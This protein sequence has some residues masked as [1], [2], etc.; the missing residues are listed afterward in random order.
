MAG[1]RRPYL[2]PDPLTCSPEKIEDGI[3]MD[4]VEEY[5]KKHEARMPRYNY[6]ENLYKGFHDIY[7]QPE[8]E[9]WKPDWRLV[10]NFP[11]YITNVFMGY[12]Y[13]I[14][15]K[16][17]H[18][19][20]KVQEAISKFEKNNE[21]ADHEY[22]LLKKACIYGHSWEYF[23]Q[24]ENARTKVTL[25]TPKE[26]FVVYD[27]TMNSR[28]L[29]AVRYGYHDSN[30]QNPYEKF[31]EILTRDSIIP[32]EGSEKKDANDN[33]YGYIPCVE[34]RLNEERIGLFEETS[35]LTEVF[36]H[37]IGEKAN[38]VDAF[39]DAYLAVLGCELSDDGYYKLRDNRL[40]NLYGT[41]NAKDILVQF[42]QKPTADGTQENLLNRLE[43]L[44]FHISMVANMSDESF[45]SSSSGISL[46]YKL[47]TMGDLASGF[48]RKIKKSIK[49]RYKIFC[50]LST[51][52]S[53]KTAWE[54]IEVKTTRNVP[55]NVLEEAQ[56]AQALEGTVSKETQLSVLSIV[57]SV[58][59]E[60]KKMEN[61]RNK[62]TDDVVM[63]RMFEKQV[64]ESGNIGG[65]SN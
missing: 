59:D 48:D 46:S 13:G 62:I 2:L 52:V 26:L 53:D 64:Q 15:I 5:I 23:Y 51:N 54:N 49:K 45:G 24:D 35:G 58:K 7:K 22:E 38:D 8:K 18:P 41:D 43:R 6:L 3:T 56:T 31:G 30:S 28:A 37:T 47:L 17:T 11:W 20:D 34:Y 14:P 36:N 29:F 32:F 44:I 61:E 65:G 19:D 50:S 1:N 60:I 57:H 25:C 33:P 63:N 55:K 9:E 4:L 21:M 40:I 39:A 42:L 12:G 27:D 16:T 10:V